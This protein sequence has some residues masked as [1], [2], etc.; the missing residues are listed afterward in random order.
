MKEK[1]IITI[2][3]SV[4]LLNGC[5]EPSHKDLVLRA[6]DGCEPK[7]CVEDY[8]FFSSL[9]DQELKKIIKEKEKNKEKSATL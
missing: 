6:I 4:L 1:I 7:N 3:L 2:L 8:D 5:G 9:S